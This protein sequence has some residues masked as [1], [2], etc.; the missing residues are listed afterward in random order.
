MNTH[1]QLSAPSPVPLPLSLLH[2]RLPLNSG[3]RRRVGIPVPHANDVLSGRGKTINAHLGNLQFH[4]VISNIKVEYIA[5]SKEN[6]KTYGK[7]VFQAITSLNPPGRFLKKDK[8]DGL[9]YDIGE[10]NALL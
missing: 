4:S 9:W 1:N 8:E 6:K 7:L 10:K 5:A 2:L 3:Q